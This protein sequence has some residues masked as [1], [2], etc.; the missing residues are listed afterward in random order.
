MVFVQFSFLP[1]LNSVQFGGNFSPELMPWWQRLLCGGNIKREKN[2]DLF[3]KKH[4]CF[5]RP[6]EGSINSQEKESL[7]KG[8]RRNSLQT[9]CLQ[10][11]LSEVNQSYSPKIS[12]SH[13]YW[14][15]VIRIK[16][17]TVR[18]SKRLILNHNL[19]PDIQ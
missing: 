4:E 13:K 16:V 11:K 5:A 8:R 3:Q 2:N 12:I 10:I 18:L 19:Q 15:L 1:D 6:E 7:L 14:K 17:V 9:L